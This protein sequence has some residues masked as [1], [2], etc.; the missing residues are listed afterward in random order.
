MARGAP[1]RQDQVL[2]R[3]GGLSACRY[4]T[5]TVAWKRL[6]FPRSQSAHSRETSTPTV[7]FTSLAFTAAVTASSHPREDEP[8]ASLSRMTPGAALGRRAG[9][10]S[11]RGTDTLDGGPLGLPV[12]GGLRRLDRRQSRDLQELVDHRADPFVEHAACLEAWP[13]REEHADHH[14]DHERTHCSI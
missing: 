1:R 3:A 5:F 9:T 10:G 11:F 2:E 13:R 4:A 12:R 8:V 6:S 7:A 14:T